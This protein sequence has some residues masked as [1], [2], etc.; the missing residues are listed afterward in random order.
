MLLVAPAALCTRIHDGDFYTFGSLP[1]VA[2][3]LIARGRWSTGKL[4]KALKV[5]VLA[6]VV[7]SFCTLA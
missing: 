4:K 1:S 3:C 5:E 7:V 2:K 6:P